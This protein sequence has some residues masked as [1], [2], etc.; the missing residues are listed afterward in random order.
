M[1]RE[2]TLYT[3]HT[4]VSPR[5]KIRITALL[6]C[7]GKSLLSREC[8]VTNNQGEG[9]QRNRQADTRDTQQTLCLLIGENNVVSVGRTHRVG[10]CKHKR[11]GIDIRSEGFV[12]ESVTQFRRQDLVPDCAGDCISKCTT[13]I[14][15]G[16]VE[17]SDYSEIYGIV[18][19]RVLCL[20]GQSLLRNT[21]FRA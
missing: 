13:D 12:A 15:G 20:I 5:S 1:L 21:D 11:L 14:V 3:L 7:L 16:E 10:R 2:T 6:L 8:R 18:S 17:T 19:T 4:P 9:N